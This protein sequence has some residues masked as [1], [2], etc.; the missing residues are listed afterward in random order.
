MCKYLV[1]KYLRKCVRTQV[2]KY[3][4]KC[5]S[6]Q[7]LAQ[8]FAQWRKGTSAQIRKYASVQVVAQLKC[9]NMRKC[10]SAQV[11]VQVLAQVLKCASST[12]VCKYASAQYASAQVHKCA[13]RPTQGGTYGSA[14]DLRKQVRKYMCKCVSVQVRK[15]ANAQVC[16]YLR[17]FTILQECTSAQV[18]AQVLAQV[19]KYESAQVFAQ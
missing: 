6:T 4:R 13:S 5:A 1:R 2:R 18:L 3:L 8:V 11:L 16:K 14:K 9:A 17:K 7:I 19:R 12:Q 15:C 10:A